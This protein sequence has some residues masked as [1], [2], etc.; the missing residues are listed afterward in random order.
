MLGIPFS[1]YTDAKFPYI[2]IPSN[3][4][5]VYGPSKPFILIEFV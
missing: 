3:S 2:G 4:T 5:E 1:P